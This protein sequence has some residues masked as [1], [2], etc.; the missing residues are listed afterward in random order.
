MSEVNYSQDKFSMFINY[1]SSS[2]YPLSLII[3]PLDH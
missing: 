1:T 3:Y 2:N